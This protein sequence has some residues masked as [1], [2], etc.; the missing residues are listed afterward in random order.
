MGAIAAGCRFY[1]GYPITPSSEIM[2]RMAVE[3][4]K[5]DGTFIQMEDEIGSI[6]AVIG[7]AWTGAKSMTATSGPGLSLMLENIG[8]GIMTETPCVIVDVQ[9]AGPS[10]GQATKVAS[11]DVMQV[12]WGTHGDYEIIAFSPWSVQE[13]Y[14]LTIKAFNLAETYRTPVFLLSDEAVGHLREKAELSKD[15]EIIKRSPKSDKPFFGPG[16]LMPTLGQGKKLSI[17]GSTHDEWGIRKTQSPEIQAKFTTHFCDK[18]RLNADRITEYEEYYL[19]GQ[20]T[21]LVI[22]YGFTAR[23]ALRAVELAREKGGKAGLL[24]LKTV[25]PMPENKLK[26]LPT[27]I[28]KIIVPEMN[29]GQVIREI[30]RFI[31]C[32][33]VPLNKTNGQVITPSEI[34]SLL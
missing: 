16:A 2:E 26:S 7:A 5:A 20:T 3:L 6:G 34:E 15:V 18:I 22:A 21:V 8:Y 25:W 1:A 14:E 30:Q 10:T 19:D 33:I 17:T 28:S 24:R 29:Q 32:P 12:R 11:G 31:K 4:P 13:M 23:S 27:S 9:R